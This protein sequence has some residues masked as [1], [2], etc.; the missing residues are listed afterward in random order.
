MQSI[1]ADGA[2]ELLSS[3]SGEVRFAALSY[4]VFR[5]GRIGYFN[6]QGLIPRLS[7]KRERRTRSQDRRQVKA[8]PAQGDRGSARIV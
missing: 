1:K 3:Q 6:R 2:E 5:R 8:P 7:E 4:A